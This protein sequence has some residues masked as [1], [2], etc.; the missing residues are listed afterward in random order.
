VI[1][2]ASLLSGFVERSGL[3]QVAVFLALGAIVGP[4][5]IRLVDVSVQ[6]PILRVVATLSLTLV[7]FTDAVSLNLQE[8]RTHKKLS[9]LV[10][11]PGTVISAALIGLLAAWLLKL[12]AIAATMIGAALASTDPVLLRGIIRRPDL[13]T[14]VQQAL[15]IE[16]G[17]NDVVLLP[18][19]LVAIALGKQGALPG[20]EWGRLALDM[21]ILS[22]AAGTVVALA[23]IGALEL[24]R[25]KIGIR[26]DYESIYSL[27]IAFTSYAAAEAVH[28]SGF[29]AAFVAGITV[30]ALDVELCDCFLEYGETTAEMALL[31]AFVLLGVSIIWSGLA[32][33]SLGILLFTALAFIAR[34]GAFLPALALAK[35][36]SSDRWFIAWFGPRGLSTL[37]LILLPV[38]AGVAGSEEL[39]S[40]CCFVVLCS[41]LVHGFSPVITRRGLPKRHRPSV[42]KEPE[43]TQTGAQL[44][45]IPPPSESASSSEYVDVDE[46]QSGKLQLVDARSHR[47]F[48]GSNELAANATRIDPDRA[49]ADATRKGVPRESWLAIFCA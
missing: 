10:L 44:R 30:N 2:I 26:R 12:P 47:S 32:V 29:I 35:I 5:G 7:L 38:F 20:S 21:L 3:P 1:F 6:S 31:F 48:D 43:K 42:P 17:L 24:V 41:V 27:G 46:L 33:A 28:G 34:M 11:G 4:Y 18:I 36:S 9:L 22:P 40:I 39:L 37:L 25:R 15:R 16:S 8:L 23:G 14:D 45:V 19:V 49:V 13:S